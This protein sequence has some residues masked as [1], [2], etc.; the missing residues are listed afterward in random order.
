[1]GSNKMKITERT[2]GAVGVEDTR[3]A[4]IY[5]ILAME[6]IGKSFSDA[7]TLIITSTRTDRID[8]SPARVQDCQTSTMRR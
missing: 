4:Y 7:F 6:T 8:V 3:D 5:T 1:M 2:A